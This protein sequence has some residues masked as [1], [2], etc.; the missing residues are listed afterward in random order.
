MFNLTITDHHNAYFY[1]LR[2]GLEPVMSNHSQ[3][4][5]YLCH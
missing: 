2:L 3:H 4:A 5:N 1:F